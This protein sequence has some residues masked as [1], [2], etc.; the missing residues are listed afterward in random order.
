M[1]DGGPEEL[2]GSEGD[3]AVAFYP[4]PNNDCPL[5]CDAVLT[6]KAAMYEH[7]ISVHDAKVYCAH[8]GVANYS[9]VGSMTSHV[10]KCRLKHPARCDAVMDSSAAPR[11]RAA[12]SSVRRGPWTDGELAA[13]AAL[14]ARMEEELGSNASVAERLHGQFPFRTLSAISQC[15]TKNPKYREAVERA[16]AVLLA[17]QEQAATQQSQESGGDRGGTA[18]DFPAVPPNLPEMV[19]ALMHN[20][21]L[22]EEAASL[23]IAP[24]TY[25]Q[26]R[27]L[28]SR[29]GVRPGRPPRRRVVTRALP[30]LARGR[31]RMSRRKEKYKKHQRLF[32]K[33]S[34]VFLDE[35]ANESTPVENVVTIQAVHE[36]YDGIF[37]GT[38][39]K[40][41]SDLTVPAEAR[42]DPKADVEMFTANEISR[43]LKTFSKRS[44]LGPDGY[45]FESLYNV[46]PF[47]LAA[48][49][50][51]WSIFRCVPPELK[52]S[53]TVFIP[54]KRVARDPS[55]FRPL[56]ISSTLT[57]LYSKCILSRLQ[58]LVSLHPLQAGFS[59]DKA[60][61]NN[62][63]L[64]QGLIKDRRS[65]RKAFHAAF[66]DIS[67]AFDSLSHDA[68]FSA[69]QKRGIPDAYIDTIRDMY[70]GSTTTFTVL[71]DSDDVPVAVRRGVKQGDPLSPFLFALALDPL[72]MRLNLSDI[73]LK[74]GRGRIGCLAFAD[75]MCLTA[76]SGPALESLIAQAIAHFAGI[77]LELNLKKSQYLGWDFNGKV[78]KFIDAPPKL[79]VGADFLAPVAKD[80]P[81]AYLGLLLYRSR[82]P[83]CDLDRVKHELDLVAGAALKPF[84]RLKVVNEVVLPRVLYSLSNS[85][86]VLTDSRRV[87]NC[88]RRW[89]KRALHLPHSYPN[90]LLV[91]PRRHGGIGLLDIE[92]TA[93]SVQCKSIARLK[94]LGHEVVDDVLDGFLGLH[95]RRLCVRLGV[96]DQVSDRD[97]LSKLL[98]ATREER[99]LVERERLD[100]SLFSFWDSQL[101]NAWLHP[102]S[103][104]LKDGE[105][106]EALRLRGNVYPTRYLFN[107]HAE[108]ANTRMC[109]R[110]NSAPETPMHILQVCPSVKPSRITRHD[111]LRDRLADLVKRRKPDAVVHVERTFT[112][113]GG[114]RL[115][116]DLVFEIAG[117]VHIVDMV[118]P[119]DVV[120]ASLDEA[121][122][123]KREKYDVLRDNF[124]GSAYRADGCAIG[125]RGLI[126][127]RVATMLK[128]LGLTNSDIRFLV[129]GA[130][131]GSLIVLG[132]FMQM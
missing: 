56:T 111:W 132:R 52:R 101:S 18:F 13:L 72:L 46:P 85:T 97:E 126:T 92:R 42:T 75:D 29:F 7:L 96:P 6:S 87:W 79:R 36:V 37:S 122:R 12:P 39:V 58:A 123:G 14:E 54:K 41:T 59:L 20:G 44:A 2:G 77:G 91:L 32:N 117:T 47:I 68:I 112:S 49:F 83:L 8:C 81:I 69:M 31:N 70:R 110:C 4:F 74:T 33:G 88:I 24:F 5:R 89:I 116:P 71:G 103:R 113:S 127:N 43:C 64:L 53:R 130:L 67:K 115:R 128:T 3:D 10:A 38:S 62:L 108:D 84:Q 27:T 124:V 25:A 9:R 93:Q 109:R 15:R 30:S 40:A 121:A 90:L 118:V 99:L 120:P 107:R 78:K 50:T 73:A 129:A 35:I 66:L 17:E 65:S 45:S 95:Q 63:L 48:V 61:G 125:A 22:A 131:R 86:A 82:P 100:K 104:L 21:F 80:E 106:I 114:E 105:K 34:K 19:E 94:R 102:A 60:T 55:D 23:C 51:N 57:R 16:K 26:L 76:D 28:L 98:E 1:A 11:T 119:W